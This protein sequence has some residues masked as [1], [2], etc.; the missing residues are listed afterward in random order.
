MI[1]VKI[2]NIINMTAK[3]YL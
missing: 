3:R 1:E 2:G